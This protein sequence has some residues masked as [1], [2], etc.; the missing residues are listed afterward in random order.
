MY[1]ALQQAVLCIVSFTPHNNPMRYR[2]H[3]LPLIDGETEVQNDL[4]I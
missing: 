4:V 1:P 2:Y 3:C